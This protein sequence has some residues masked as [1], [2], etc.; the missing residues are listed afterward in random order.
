MSTPKSF[1]RQLFTQLS[2]GAIA[3]ALCVSFIFSWLSSNEIKHLYIQ[4][5][6]QVTENFSNATELALLYDSGENA[7]D[8]AKAALAFPSIIHVFIVNNKNQVLLQQGTASKRPIISPEDIERIST[9]AFVDEDNSS[10]FYAA[11]V[12]TSKDESLISEQDDLS[13]VENNEESKKENDEKLGYVLIIQD[14]QQLRDIQFNTFS[15]NLLI[16][17]IY[18]LAIILLL[19][20]SLKQLLRPMDDLSTAMVKTSEGEIHKIDDVNGPREIH[21]IALIYNEMLDAIADRDSQLRDQNDKLEALVEQRTAQLVLARDEALD[22]SKQKSMFLANVSHELRTPLQ[23]II[24]YSD[25]LKESL[26]DEGIDDF[27]DDVDRITHNA[28]HLLKLINSILDLAKVESARTTLTLTETDINS[29]LKQAETAVTPVINK[30]HNEL[31]MEVNGSRQRLTIDAQKTL[32]IIINLLSNAGK[33]TDKGKITLIAKLEENELSIA[34]R[35][36]GIGIAED[37]QELVFSPFRQADGSFTRDFEGTGLGLSISK[38]FCALMGGELTL[39][40]YPGKGSTFTMR[41]PLPV[42]QAK[43]EDLPTF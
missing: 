3:L 33:F 34:V 14:K 29:L 20:F 2:I 4:E 19:H 24:G 40:S 13:T 36:T 26:E 11:A 38:Y 6:L 41:I 17:L 43:Q 28:Q 27:I 18:S 31:S 32:Q 25:I 15:T 23:S 10:W 5:G 16:G 35:D 8:A 37:Q 12:F 21:Q 22:A 30:N 39:Q 1:R 9:A 42:K 7:K